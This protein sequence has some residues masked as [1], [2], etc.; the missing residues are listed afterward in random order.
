MQIVCRWYVTNLVDREIQV[1]AARILRPETTGMVATQHPSGNIF[2]Q[3]PILP[4]ATT[5]LS[6]NFWI[7]PP[8]RERGQ[9]F[10]ATVVFV[11]QFG[12]ERRVKNV[13]FRYS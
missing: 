10:K 3:Y 7:K 2:G 11:D 6:A 8:V 13:I 1:L 9:E 12:N 4:G 5:E